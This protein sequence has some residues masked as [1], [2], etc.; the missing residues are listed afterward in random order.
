MVL[1]VCARKAEI[2]L[3]ETVDFR[4]LKKFY[5][6]SFLMA[7]Y[8]KSLTFTCLSNC[9]LKYCSYFKEPINRIY[10]IVQAEDFGDLI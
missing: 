3:T 10:F 6:D 5:P 9:L 7:P 1:R 4:I 2:Q 8:L